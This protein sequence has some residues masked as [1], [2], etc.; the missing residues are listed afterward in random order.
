MSMTKFVTRPAENSREVTK[1]VTGICGCAG[2]SVVACLAMGW[3]P[4]DMPADKHSSAWGR[5]MMQ[6]RTRVAMRRKGIKQPIPPAPPR[7]R[8]PAPPARLP[9]E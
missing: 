2:R 5:W 6:R 7:K 1:I 4:S 9:L 3:K 8:R